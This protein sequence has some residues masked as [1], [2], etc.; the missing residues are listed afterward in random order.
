MTA[1]GYVFPFPRARTRDPIT[2]HLAAAQV[3]TADSHY[4]AI[5]DALAGW[6]PM[7][8]DEIAALAGLEPSQVARRLPEMRRIGL[9]DLTGG[10]VQSRSG[11][12]E[13]E[14]Y[15]NPQKETA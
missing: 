12:Q 8:K 6:G 4:Q 1:G 7:G 2:S 15:A 3:T 11:R 10:T 13:R 9:V 5:H 14:W